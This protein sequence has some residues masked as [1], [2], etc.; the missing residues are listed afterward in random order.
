MLLI[1]QAVLIAHSE[2]QLVMYEM[3]VVITFLS[4]VA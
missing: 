1:L 3:E 4:Y 2:P